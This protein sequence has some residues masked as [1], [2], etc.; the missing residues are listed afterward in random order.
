MGRLR[1]RVWTL[2]GPAGAASSAA[3]TNGTYLAYDGIFH[4]AHLPGRR[5]RPTAPPAATSSS[6]ATACRSSSAWRTCGCRSPSPP[7]D[8]ASP[9]GWPVVIYAHGTGGSY[10]SFNDG[11]ATRIAPRASRRSPSTRCCT[12]RATPGR[13]P[14]VD[15]FNFQNPHAGARQRDPGRRRR[16]LCAAAG[17]GLRT[18]ASAASRTR[19]HDPVRS[20]P[21][22][23]SSATRRAG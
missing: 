21:R 1:E 16:L 11:T 23:T 8:P 17:P 13:Q 18:T 14:R 10:H 19:A 12:A 4:G 9:G 15:F 20:P 7:A 22:S 6:A 2:A 3:E 5:R